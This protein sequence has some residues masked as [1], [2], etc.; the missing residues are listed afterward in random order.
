MAANRLSSGG[1]QGQD[2]AEAVTRMCKAGQKKI[3]RKIGIAGQEVGSSSK[4]KWGP[5]TWSSGRRRQ[6]TRV[7]IQRDH[8]GEC[9]RID[10]RYEF[11]A[12]KHNKSQARDE[13]KILH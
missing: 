1:N 7:M 12:R 5:S 4:K 9:S 11:Q 6:W 10:K 3:I 13:E 8:S 2:G